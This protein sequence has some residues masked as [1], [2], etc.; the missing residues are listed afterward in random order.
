MN[1]GSK[2]V[3]DLFRDDISNISLNY[4]IVTLGILDNQQKEVRENDSN[5][6]CQELR[7]LRSRYGP[8]DG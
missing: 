7:F 6:L 5:Y 3:A 8:S 2:K 1:T 4:A